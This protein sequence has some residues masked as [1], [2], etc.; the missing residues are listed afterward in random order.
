MIM[1]GFR[2]SFY[3]K[4]L[5]NLF[6]IP[7]FFFSICF[8]A[9]QESAF[10]ISSDF[11]PVIKE[12]SRY[13]VVFQQLTQTSSYNDIQYAAGKECIEDFYLYTCRANETLF[14]LHSATG[15]PYDTLATLNGI[16]GTDE[17][18]SGRKIIIPAEKGVF[19]PVKPVNA[20]EVLLRAEMKA[21]ASPVRYI[22]D[23]REFDFLQGE[24]FSQAQRAFFLDSS[25][26][27]PLDTRIVSSGFG[28]RTSPV[29]GV[30]KFHKGVDFAAPEGESVYAC[31]G[32][33][34][35]LAVRNDAIFGNYIIISHTGGLTSVYA[36]LSKI[37]VRQGQTV[38]SGQTIGE[39]GQTGAATGPHLH[40]EIRRNGTATNPE[41]LLPRQ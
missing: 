27:L 38:R 22:V 3:F 37:S 8:S 30:W 23:S 21:D 41:E 19:V 2:P 10:I 32:G 11:L 9:A 29:Y 5:K 13:D 25:F 6:V 15:I 1:N 16:S 24:R 26:R 18:L 36:H 4:V 20:V 12:L 17:R 7:L 34:V 35:S 31:K 14:S 28:Y 40:F 33:T 39:I